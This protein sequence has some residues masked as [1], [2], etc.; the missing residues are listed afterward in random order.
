MIGTLR[1]SAV[2]EELHERRRDLICAQRG[3]IGAGRACARHT[4]RPSPRRH[5]TRRG[6]VA[7]GMGPLYRRGPTVPAPTITHR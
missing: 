1:R 4:I 5:S 7:T 3:R 6:A 2:D